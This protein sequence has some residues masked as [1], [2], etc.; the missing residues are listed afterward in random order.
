MS[1]WIDNY[2]I[3]TGYGFNPNT[4][5]VIRYEFDE[6]GRP[7][8]GKCVFRGKWEDCINYATVKEEN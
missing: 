5:T 3:E 4:S 1:T 7:T 2:Y 6:N 8:N